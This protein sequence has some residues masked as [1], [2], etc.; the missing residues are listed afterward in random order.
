MFLLFYPITRHTSQGDGTGKE[1]HNHGKH[2]QYVTS[3]KR[4]CAKNHKA[5]QEPN[6]SQFHGKG[7][8]E[9]PFPFLTIYQSKC[10]LHNSLFLRIQ[11]IAYRYAT[12]ILDGHVSHPSCQ[13]RVLL[14]VERFTNH[15][16]CNTHQCGYSFANTM[17]YDDSFIHAFLC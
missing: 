1:V 12:K 15:F 13:V 16:G 6:Q 4:Q 5:H 17:T 2:T 8:A 10:F 7:K 9:K 14:V 3:V 11:L